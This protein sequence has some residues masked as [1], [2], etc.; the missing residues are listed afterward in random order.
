MFL[1]LVYV[2]D[3]GL[4]TIR[5]F[6]NRSQLFNSRNL[7]NSKRVRFSITSIG[8]KYGLT[9]LTVNSISNCNI[10]REFIEF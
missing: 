9:K 6:P 1:I 2:L 3:I 7:L 5:G 4:R 8:H 10:F